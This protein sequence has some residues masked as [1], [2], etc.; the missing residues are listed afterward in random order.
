MLNLGGSLNELLYQWDEHGV[1]G[2]HR[3]EK[4]KINFKLETWMYLP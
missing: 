3:Y 1:V 4:K 2:D